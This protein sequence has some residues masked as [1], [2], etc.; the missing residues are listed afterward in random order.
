[1]MKKWKL[2][3]FI[4]WIFILLFPVILGYRNSTGELLF[5]GLIFNPIDGYSYYAKMQQGAAGEWAFNLPYSAETNND[6]YIFTLYLFFGHL[7]RILGISIPIIYQFFRILFAILLFF[8]LLEILK[9]VF[10]NEDIFFKGAFISLLFGGGLGWIYFLSG[11]LP[12]DFWVAE[13]FVF[14]SSLSNPHFILSLLIFVML[15]QII[16]RNYFGIWNTILIFI[17]STILVSISPF[18]AIIMGFVFLMNV[19]LVQKFSKESI[20]N[21]IVFGIPVGIIGA[22]QY[23]TIRADPILNNWNTQNVTQTPSLLNLLFSFSPLLIGVFIL[24]FIFWKRKILVEKSLY[25]LIFWIFFGLLM[26]YVPFNLQRRF[27]AGYYLPLAIVFWKLLGDFYKQFPHKKQ[28]ILI[29]ALIGLSLPSSLLIFSGSL[30]AINHQDQIFYYKENILEATEWLSS[31]GSH[32]S[33]V[34][35]TEDNGRIIPALANFKVVYGHPFESINA[36][37]TKKDVDDFWANNLSEEQSWNL[38]KKYKVDYILCEYETTRNS[39]QT[40]TSTMEIMYEARN[41]A[42]FQVVN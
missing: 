22:Y 12:L 29:Y 17:F 11:D 19:I 7:S 26:A 31:K 5:S 23:L 27:L 35:A 32:K 34:L 18:S 13:A 37:Q 8:S 33:I 1:M 6:I 38:I 36:E 25:L 42:I 21:L 28:T 3:I 30:N 40:I 15:L 14:L 39:C 41:I 10:N 20:S 9:S 24:L 16:L 2:I 4:I